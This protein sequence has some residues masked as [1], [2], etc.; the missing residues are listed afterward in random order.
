MSVCVN[1][2]AYVN[3]DAGPGVNPSLWNVNK[4]AAGRVR[5]GV[6]GVLF[7]SYRD[8]AGAALEGLL[9]N[10]RKPQGSCAPAEWIAPGKADR[11]AHLTPGSASDLSS[12]ALA[13]GNFKIRRPAMPISKPDCR[14]IL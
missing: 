10:N 6:S 4:Y 9:P 11:H 1:V 3:T 7:S 5:P 14:N 8:S 12:D 2:C 13:R